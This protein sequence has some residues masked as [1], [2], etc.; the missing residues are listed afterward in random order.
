[1]LRVQHPA[2]LRGPLKDGLVELDAGSG[3]V[4]LVVEA[5]GTPEFR[6]QDIEQ[7]FRRAEQPRGALRLPQ[8]ARSCP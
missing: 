5:V 6:A 7:L 2:L 1:M 3:E 8:R 4:V